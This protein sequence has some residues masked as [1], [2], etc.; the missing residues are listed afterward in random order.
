MGPDGPSASQTRENHGTVD[1][2]SP[3]VKRGADGLETPGIALEDGQ[4]SDG[5]APTTPEN[6]EPQKEALEPPQG[7]GEGPGAD[8]PDSPTKR[9]TPNL[10]AGTKRPAD[11]PVEDREVPGS[12]GASGS[13]LSATAEVHPEHLDESF[14]LL[15]ISARWHKACVTCQLK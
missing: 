14:F 2:P 4:E 3:E 8:G 10:L 1:I 11:V 9:V 12:T 5:Y 7:A 13:V 6:Q 15:G